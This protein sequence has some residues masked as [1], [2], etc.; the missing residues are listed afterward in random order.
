VISASDD[1]LAF[2]KGRKF[3]TILADALSKQHRQSRA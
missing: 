2:A 3:R 1:L